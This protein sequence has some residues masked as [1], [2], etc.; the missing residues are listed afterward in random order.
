M[1][2]RRALLLVS[3]VFAL[4]LLFSDVPT[5]SPDFSG[6]TVK[7]TVIFQAAEPCRSAFPGRQDRYHL[8]NYQVEWGAPLVG[9]CRW[10]DPLRGLATL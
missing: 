1:L 3:G 10:R 6:L 8:G 2:A 4:L 5:F 7:S 9:P